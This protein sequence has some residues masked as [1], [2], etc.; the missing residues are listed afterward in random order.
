MLYRV[1]KLQNSTIR[2][3]V[4]KGG[5]KQLHLFEHWETSIFVVHQK[6]LSKL[7]RFF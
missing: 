6:K 5:V 7:T 4:P 2:I 3:Q 1:V